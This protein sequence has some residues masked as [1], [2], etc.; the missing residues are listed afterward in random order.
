MWDKGNADKIR[1]WK[2]LR[3]MEILSKALDSPCKC[4]RQWLECA[5]ELLERNKIDYEEFL[6]A[7]K[8]LKKDEGRGEIFC[9]LGQHIAKKYFL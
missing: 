9:L 6:F 2:A 3:R 1:E 7:V 4:K 5:L 8:E